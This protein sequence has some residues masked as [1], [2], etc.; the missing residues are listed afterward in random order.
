MAR[1]EVLQM[2][3]GI[4]KDAKPL[5]HAG[6]LEPLTALAQW[7]GWRWTPGE[8]GKM[9]PSFVMASA[10]DRP[11]SADDPGTWCDFNRAFA[12]AKARNVDGIAFV[13]TPADPFVAISLD[14]CRHPRSRSIDL[15][16]QNFLDVAH[17]SRAEATP[18]GDGI[19][20]W[21]LTTEGTA[22]VD[23]KFA[24]EINGKPIAVELFRHTSKIL[25]ITGQRLDAVKQLANLDKVITWAL[26]WGDRREAVAAEVQAA[27]P[28]VAPKPAPT[29]KPEPKP[30]A[31]VPKK[32]AP[33]PA[34]PGPAPAGYRNGVH[35]AVR[36]QSSI[37]FDLSEM[38]TIDLAELIDEPVPA[39]R[40]ICCPFHNETKPSLH[41]YPDHFYCF[42]CHAYGDHVDWLMRVKGLS[43]SAAQEVLTNWN[44]PVMSQDAA[45]G[46][47]LEDIEKA[48]KDR[49]YVLRWWN[50]AKP[51]RGTLA[52]T[53]LAETRGVDLDALPDNVDNSLRF[54][55]HCVFGPGI[56]HPCLLALMRDPCGDAPI[57]IQRIALT[58]DARKIDRMML[59]KAG[60]V[61][62]WPA[63]KQLVL[64]EGL[65]TVL[66][67]ATRLPYR[68]EPLTPAWA[69]LSDG[70]LKKF[71]LIDGVERLI[72]L[73]DNDAN[74]AGQIAAEACKRRWLEANRRVALL[75]PDRLPD[76]PKTDFNDI[77][78]ANLMCAP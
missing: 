12:A 61:K 13:L 28:A 10:P 38:T 50:S 62:L 55:R 54:H 63:G 43:H 60:V 76:R 37:M 45:A 7:C 8:D 19:T 2:S 73:A 69:A 67:A 26:A 40:K 41:I 51:I 3:E 14:N 5:V 70:G 21:G 9:R 64:G 1:R 20:I 49:A 23:W 6:P 25:P 65:E 36:A 42:G 57:G 24:F 77:V 4:V 52:E 39:N 47:A 32:P 44:G 15:W 46:L 78:L 33:K 18:L 72:V 68:D 27:A 58:L 53:Y 35:H 59:G 75:I 22:P 34:A 56:A 48:E 74:R 71:P 66:A 30:A 16:A 31:D 17:K 29:P 11:A